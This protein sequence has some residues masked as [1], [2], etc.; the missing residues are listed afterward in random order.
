MAKKPSRNLQVQSELARVR[1][2]T[3]GTPPAALLRKPISLEAEFKARA[4]LRREQWAAM[5]R[6]TAAVF[7]PILKTIATDKVAMAAAITL[8]NNM[9][10]RPRRQKLPKLVAPKIGSLIRSGSLLTFRPPPFDQSWAAGT[11]P[12][13]SGTGGL[14]TA[15]TFTGEFGARCQVAEGAGSVSAG[16]GV[17]VWF[18]P[19]KDNTA[20]RFAPSVQGYGQWDDKSWFGATAHNNGVTRIHVESWDLSGG[21][22]NLDVPRDFPQWSDATGWWD[23]HGFDQIFGIHFPVDTIFIAST[24]R[25]YRCWVEA[26]VSCDGSGDQQLWGSQANSNLQFQLYFVVFE[27]FV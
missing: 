5:S 3:G 13:N 1:T 27:Q 4:K 15:N 8:K 14:G 11:T 21:D 17:S 20:V 6:H 26:E 2:L 18:Q 16:S 7:K 19:I 12:W 24:K 10:K 22:Y 23:E 9:K 25:F